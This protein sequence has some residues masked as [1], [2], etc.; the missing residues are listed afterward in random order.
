MA[1]FSRYLLYA[2]LAGL[3]LALLSYLIG[4]SGFT[5]PLLIIG[6]LVAALG[7]R[8]IASLKGFAYTMVIFAVVCAEARRSNA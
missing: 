7:M 3:A 6:F 4:Q 5:G 2:G 8:D 1:S